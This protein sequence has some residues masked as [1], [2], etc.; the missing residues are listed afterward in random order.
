MTALDYTPHFYMMAFTAFFLIGTMA[1]LIFTMA[2]IA[3]KV[4]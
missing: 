2:R 3:R 4:G 1:G